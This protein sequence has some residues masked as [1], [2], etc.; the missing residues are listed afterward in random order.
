MV[1]S[2]VSRLTF[3]GAST[4][5]LLAS[6]LLWYNRYEHNKL[7]SHVAEAY[8]KGLGFLANSQLESGEFP[9]YYW[10]KG[11]ETKT[12]YVGTPFTASQVLYSLQFGD[13]T[14]TTRGIGDRARSYLLSEQEPPGVWRFYGKAGKHI[15]SPDVDDT[16]QAWAALFSQGIAV[17]PQALEALRA[18]RTATGLFTTWIGNPTE[19]I[20]IDSLGIDMVVN[21]NALF[22][23]SLVRQPLFEVCQHALT[24]T[25]TKAFY[26]GSIYYPSPLAYTYFLLRAYS[27]GGASCLHEAI[28]D[29]RSYVL[30]HQQLD[31]S[32]G[33][34]L[35][36]GLAVLTLLMAGYHGTALTRGISILLDRQSPDGGW[37]LAPLYKGAVLPVYYGSRPLTTSLILEALGKHLK[38]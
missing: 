26:H 28:P 33:N 2:R 21:V 31:G 19:W 16:S 38:R 34:D 8:A 24:Y 11:E 20:G 4:L 27:S 13:P 32:W 37:A 14:E 29:V 35:E 18:S 10:F 1:I 15:L 9:T 23:F 22:L 6:F 36:T 25:K 3:L 17:D 5:F 12:E 7:R 30:D